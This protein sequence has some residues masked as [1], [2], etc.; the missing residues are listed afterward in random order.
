MPI[1]VADVRREGD[2]VTSSRSAARS[3]GRS[4]RPSALAEEGISVEVVDPRTLRRSTRDT[5]V[6]SV[7]RTGRL[8]VAQE[9]TSPYSFAAEV[10]ALAAEECL[11]ELKTAARPRDLAVHQRPDPGAAGRGARPRGRR[12]RRRRPRERWEA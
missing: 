9:A 6:E 10:C 3:T 7:R 4:R 1:G 2:D 11:S 8:V 5:I 12:R